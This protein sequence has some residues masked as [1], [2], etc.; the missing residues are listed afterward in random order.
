MRNMR[1]FYLKFPILFALRKE[2]KENPIAKQAASQ[3]EINIGQ[4]AI[5][6]SV[7][8]EAEFSGREEL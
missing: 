2:L 6:Q 5:A 7:Q 8:I 3:F 4:Q 1:L